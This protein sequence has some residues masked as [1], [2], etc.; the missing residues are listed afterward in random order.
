VERIENGKE[1]F[2]RHGENSVAALDA[3]LVDKDLAAGACRH[4]APLVR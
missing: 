1:A 2:A 4:A 3:E